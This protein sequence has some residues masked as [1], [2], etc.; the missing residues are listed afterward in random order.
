M[1]DYRSEAAAVSLLSSK[2]SDRQHM[3]K[4]MG[5]MWLLCDNV[6]TDFALLK[7]KLK[8]KEHCCL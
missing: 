6:M 4:I 3:L 1:T 8:L 7:I 5:V 2:L